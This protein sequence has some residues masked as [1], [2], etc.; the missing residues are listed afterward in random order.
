[1]DRLFTRRKNIKEMAGVLPNPIEDPRIRDKRR[2]QY[3]DMQL[4]RINNRA[5]TNNG[6]S[7]KC[8]RRN[9]KIS[10]IR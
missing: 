7:L 6:R 10:R 1:M 4:W 5:S 2:Q 9:W 8:S 3:V